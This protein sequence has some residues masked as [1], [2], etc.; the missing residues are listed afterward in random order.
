MSTAPPSFSEATS[1]P[2]PSYEEAINQVFEA[3]D[4]AYK[5][6]PQAAT[7]ALTRALGGKDADAAFVKEM[8]NLRV[9]ITT[10][11][12]LFG[13]VETGIATFDA[14]KLPDETGKITEW[15]PKWKVIRAVRFSPYN[16]L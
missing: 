9:S 5:K 12:T 4:A 8:S 1:D 16:H 7:K 15:Q 13:T 10:L 14:E 11:N 3:W 2:P 6:D